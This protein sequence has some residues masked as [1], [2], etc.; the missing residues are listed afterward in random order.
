MIKKFYRRGPS[1]LLTGNGGGLL[2]NRQYLRVQLHLHLVLLLELGV[3]CR[4]L[5]VDP[6]LER[7]A[8]DG[9]DDIAQPLSGQLLDLIG[10]LRQDEHDLRM[11]LGELDEVLDLESLKMW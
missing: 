7:L 1:N 4:Y 6:L 5:L 8:D 2:K 11:L 10:V 3:A 9:V